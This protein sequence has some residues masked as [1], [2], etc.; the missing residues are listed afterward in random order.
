MLIITEKIN[1]KS[2]ETTSLKIATDMKKCSR[3]K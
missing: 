3:L 1:I 2:A